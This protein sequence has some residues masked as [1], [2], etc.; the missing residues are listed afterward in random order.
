MTPMVQT[1][2]SPDSA[3]SHASAVLV[4]GGFAPYRCF[5][6]SFSFAQDHTP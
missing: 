3:L 2:V 4:I 1:A 6:L 5:D